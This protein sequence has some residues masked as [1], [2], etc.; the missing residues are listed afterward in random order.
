MRLGRLAGKV[1]KRPRPSDIAVTSR[2]VRPR[3]RLDDRVPLFLTIELEREDDDIF[4]RMSSHHASLSVG[5]TKTKLGIKNLDEDFSE[6]IRLAKRSS[7][8]PKSTFRS[9]ANIG[10]EL[11]TRLFAY[12]QDI[13]K[14]IQRHIE[15]EVINSRR[16]EPEAYNIGA[17]TPARILVVTD[18]INIPWELLYAKNP[19]DFD[20]DGAPGE[21][22]PQFFLGAN[23]VFQKHLS[24]IPL[25]ASYEKR[26]GSKQGITVFGD[27]K[28]RY[29][30]E[31]EIPDIEN[32]FLADG[33]KF[34]FPEPIE[35]DVQ[36]G[37]MGEIDYRLAERINAGAE[38]ILHF[39]CHA[40][41]KDGRAQIRVSNNYYQEERPLAR[42]LRQAGDRA[43]VF[44]NACELALTRCSEKCGLV[45]AFLDKEYLGVVA[46]EIPVK[47]EQAARFANL[48]Y[49]YF[50]NRQNRSL[51]NAVYFARQK[52]LENDE[53]L[54]GFTYATYGS[55]DLVRT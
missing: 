21:I 26:I 7:Q 15:F 25:R 8:M 3:L 55:W 53:S 9:L 28:L 54:V 48:V 24:E 27:N 22:D 19:S 50:L 17:F 4:V 16:S 47:D 6:I 18:G 31:H 37:Q 45:N 20:L 42:E 2:E 32:L 12:S 38:P 49:E 23:F 41:M 11:F 29:A 39:A 52:L 14:I 34:D 30:I 35:P 13:E 1:K 10:Y 46:T 44:L 51:L 33:R 36:S 43:F 40:V 5:R